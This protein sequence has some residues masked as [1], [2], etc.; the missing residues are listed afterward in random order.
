MYNLN[1]ALIHFQNQP[2]SKKNA[3]FL[4]KNSNHAQNT[5]TISKIQNK[6]F[7]IYTKNAPGAFTAAGA[8]GRK[9]KP[10]PYFQYITKK[11]SCYK[12]P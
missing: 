1:N 8:S 6:F 4:K 12:P 5:L 2:F 11:F 9:R 10:P 7:L 3:T